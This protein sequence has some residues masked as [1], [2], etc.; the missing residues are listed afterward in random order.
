MT[1]IGARFIGKSTYL[2][3]LANRPVL[4]QLAA[5]GGVLPWDDSLFWLCPSN[6]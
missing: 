6:S 5:Q 3:L 1:S 4:V 2:T